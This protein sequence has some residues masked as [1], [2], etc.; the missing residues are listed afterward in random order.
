MLT[1]KDLLLIS[2]EYFEILKK[3]NFYIEVLSKCTKHCWIIYKHGSPDN[4]P[5]WLYHKHKQSNQCYHLHRRTGNIELAV[6]E[7]LQH[8][9]YQ[10]R[11][12]QNVFKNQK[13][14]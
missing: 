9:K 4:Y 5:V 8:D 1:R 13:S 12:R 6:N 11:G 14:H 10:L 3:N 2:S 7:I